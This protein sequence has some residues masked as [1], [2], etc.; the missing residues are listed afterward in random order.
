MIK[1]KV[2][3]GLKKALEKMVK[4]ELVGLNWDN[5]KFCISNDGIKFYD[6]SEYQEEQIKKWFSG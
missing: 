2:K 4:K 5:V 3:I 1:M 6:L